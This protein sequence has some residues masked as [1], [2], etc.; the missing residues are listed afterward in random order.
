[1]S[2]RIFCFAFCFCVN[3]WIGAQPK[4]SW[5]K[6]FIAMLSRY[7]PLLIKWNFENMLSSLAKRMQLHESHFIWKEEQFGSSVFKTYLMYRLFHSLYGRTLPRRR[8][9]YCELVW[10]CFW[11]SDGV[12]VSMGAHRFHR[13]LQLNWIQLN[14]ISLFIISYVIIKLHNSSHLLNVCLNNA[15]RMQGINVLACT[16][17]TDFKYVINMCSICVPHKFWNLMMAEFW[18]KICW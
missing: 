9:G 7:F 15:N 13:I 1:M 11:P 18:K 12:W 6:K 16:I 2:G 3:N 8:V 10:Q 4:K 14:W 5:K 17:D